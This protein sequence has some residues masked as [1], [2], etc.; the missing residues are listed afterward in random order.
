MTLTIGTHAPDF[1]LRDQH[2]NVVTLD[3]LKGAPSLIVF[4]PF[5]FTG[6]CEDE[7]CAIRD[8]LSEL[9]DL[10]A[11]VVAI[12]CHAIPTNAKWAELNDFGFPV[13]SDFW[14][15][16]AVATAYDNFNADVGCA[17][18]TT[19]VLDAEGVI[20]EVVKVDSLGEQREF[21]HYTRALASV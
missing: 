7:L 2:R 17:M 6:N 20:R 1:S 18:R 11:T 14:P 5:P 10:D 19:Y 16:G 13:L 15:H 12:T 4:I 8:R 3:D 21:D 9:N